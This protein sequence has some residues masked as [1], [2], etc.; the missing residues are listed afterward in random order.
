MIARRVTVAVALAVLC[1][2]GGARAHVDTSPVD[3]A[4]GEG[5]VIADAIAPARIGDSVHFEARGRDGRVDGWIQ[6][7]PLLP[8]LDPF[9]SWDGVVS[10]LFVDGK[11]A[12][13]GGEMRHAA[14]DAVIGR[15]A[16]AIRNT[17][18]LDYGED[19]VVLRY[20]S[21]LSGTCTERDFI[22]V[23]LVVASVSGRVHDGARDTI[24]EQLGI[25]L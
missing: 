4:S 13:L 1:A 17:I 15:F 22:G 7:R 9:A 3:R 23:P 6:Y 12:I 10:C 18:D 11:L 14:S 16:L 21:D 20:G 5:M 2:A 19:P 25:P 8:A 24:D